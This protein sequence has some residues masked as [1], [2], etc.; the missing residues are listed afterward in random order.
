VSFKKKIVLKLGIIFTFFLSNIKLSDTHNGYRYMKKS[1]LQDIAITIDG[2][3][4]AS[5]IIDIIA[6]KKLRYKEV[7]VHIKYT[8]YSLEK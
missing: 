4:H 5:E 8:E 2:M 6:Q 7:P 3:G 1:S